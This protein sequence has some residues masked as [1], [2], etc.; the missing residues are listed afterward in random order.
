MLPEGE[1]FKDILQKE[2]LQDDY[3]ASNS[4][5]KKT[6]DVI[7]VIQE[8]KIGLRY[9]DLT[10][11]FPYQSSRGNNYMMEAYHYDGNVIRIEALKK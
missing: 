9:M 1:S 4:P 5:N 3:P 8:K 10:G 7:Y 6:N 2:I 11:R